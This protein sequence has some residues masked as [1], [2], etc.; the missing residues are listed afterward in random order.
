MTRRA[1]RPLGAGI[2]E[3]VLVLTA[4]VR[5]PVQF[6]NHEIGAARA[7]TG[8]GTARADDA[9]L[10]RHER[11]VL[12]R[13]RLQG[14]GGGRAV[15][16][17]AGF[18]LPREEQASGPARPPRDVGRN[19]RVLAAAQLAA[20]PAADIRPDHTQVRER[21]LQGSRD[22]ALHGIHT[23]RRFPQ[24]Q[25]RAVPFRH[26][27]V[28]LDRALQ[29]TRRVEHVL[30]HHIGTGKR[31]G[32]VAAFVRLLRWDDISAISHRHGPALHRIVHIDDVVEHLI[33]DDDGAHGVPGLLDRVGRDGSDLV[34][35][36]AAVRIEQT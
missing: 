14:D 18:L 12:L 7:A 23:L 4:D 11:P 9:G 30:H 28:G 6:T 35:V 21:N 3:H 1:E 25:P 15:P 2:H 27:A 5:A 32:R 29:R 33:V 19:H 36:V 34:S 20:E 26:A 8:V 24:R 16:H 31:R 22:L 13:T 10:E 17:G